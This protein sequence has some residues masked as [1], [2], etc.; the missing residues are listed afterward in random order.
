MQIL[1][2]NKIP[3]TNNDMLHFG[4]K[5]TAQVD[6]PVAY[7]FAYQNTYI[8]HVFEWQVVWCG[9]TNIYQKNMFKIDWIVSSNYGKLNC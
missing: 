4:N 7:N 3:K 1:V 6:N 2:P 5:F 8:E 9:S